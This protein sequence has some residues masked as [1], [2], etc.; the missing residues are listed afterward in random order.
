MK[1]L[2]LVLRPSGGI[3]RAEKSSNL[4]KT[5][6]LIT[7][8]AQGI[9]SPGKDLHCVSKATTVND[10]VCTRHMQSRKKSNV[11]QKA[12]RLITRSA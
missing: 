10:R 12:L 6:K 3:N 9:Y 1:S 5:L 2:R 11:L 4:L 8:S 7:V